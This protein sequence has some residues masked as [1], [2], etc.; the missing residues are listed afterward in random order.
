[1]SRRR[2]WPH[3]R[4]WTPVSPTSPSAWESS[5]SWKSLLISCTFTR[6]NNDFNLNLNCILSFIPGL[7]SLV[8]E[9]LLLTR[10]LRHQRR[11]TK[12]EVSFKQKRISKMSLILL[13]RGWFCHW[14]LKNAIWNSDLVQ[15]RI[16]V[17]IWILFRVIIYPY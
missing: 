2:R 11:K 16:V 5:P 14:R 17:D 13:F 10:N 3:M 7:K 9:L 6:F 15:M 8:M 1:M 4:T 12:S